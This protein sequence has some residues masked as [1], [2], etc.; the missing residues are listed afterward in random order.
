MG[1]VDDIRVLYGGNVRVF[2]PCE[3]REDLGLPGEILGLLRVSDGLM[4]T[5][6]RPGTGEV[7]PVSWIVYP[8]AMMAEETGFY[9]ETYGLEGIVFS[10]DGAGNPFLLKNDGAVVRFDAI[11]GEEVPVAGSLAEFFRIP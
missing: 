6:V 9:R 1:L 5:M 3:G 10:D 4:E 11:D 7:I 8:R 2:P